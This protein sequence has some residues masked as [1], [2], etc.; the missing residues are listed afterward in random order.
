MIITDDKYDPYSRQYKKIEMFNGFVFV[1]FVIATLLSVIISY[2]S[3]TQNLELVNRLSGV[4]IFLSM[5]GFGFSLYVREIAFPKAEDARCRDNLSNAYAVC[6]GGAK[7]RGYY[8]NSYKNPYV[9]A[10]AHTLENIFFTKEL[11][12]TVL[13]KKHIHIA[14]I[15]V[16]IV[17]AGILNLLDMPRVVIVSQFLISE[18]ILSDWIKTIW[19]KRKCEHL[20]DY[21]VAV[22]QGNPNDQFKCKTFYVT[23]AYEAA[24]AHAGI[25]IPETVFERMN[26]RLSEEWDKLNK[27]QL[28]SQITDE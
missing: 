24:K 28:A 1:A 16:G 5:I 9:V 14:A 21:M 10:A 3:D 6:F 15:A 25:L 11:L 8:N 2:F 12:N 27:E 18:P 26:S 13:L 4:H 7:T 23:T 22:F 20:F 17:I 19:L